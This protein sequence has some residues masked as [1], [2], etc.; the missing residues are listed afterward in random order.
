MKREFED[1]YKRV[2]G[3]PELGVQNCPELE[4]GL[5]VFCR[6]FWRFSEEDEM[7]ERVGAELYSC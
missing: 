5:T 1:V 4:P 6:S 2:T 7:D 3:D